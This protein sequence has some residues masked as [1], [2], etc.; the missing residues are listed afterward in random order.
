MLKYKEFIKSEN[1]VNE[2]FRTWLATFMLLLNLGLVP[3]NVYS[4]D[5]NTKKDFVDNLSSTDIV[6]ANFLKYVNDNDLELSMETFNDFKN[7]I[8]DNTINYKDVK[9]SMDKL[10]TSVGSIDYDDIMNIKPI[11]FV[12]DYADLIDD[13]IEYDFNKL[14]SDYEDSTDVEIAVLTIKNTQGYDIS[15]YSQRIGQK[16]GVGKKG[17]D[18]GLIIT[19]SV[20]DRKWNISTGYGLEYVLPDAMCKRLGEKNIP[21]NFKNGEYEKGIR[22]LIDDIMEEI[23]SENI[24]FKK[25]RMSK[26]REE[27]KAN[28]MKFLTYSMEIL[29]MIFLSY[30]VYY[31]VNRR[32]R[33]LLE[34]TEEINDYIEKAEKMGIILEKINKSNLTS[35][36]N[37]IN[38]LK[39]K[40]KDIETTNISKS[41]L[42]EISK[43]MPEIIKEYNEYIK[44]YNRIEKVSIN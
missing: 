40:L 34:L 5:M 11:N 13:N 39:N 9:R 20:E 23:G 41:R 24:E 33:K 4:S 29:L 38:T 12:S 16:W 31:L 37:S 18:N 32:K 2:G 22:E 19:I 26:E 14:L 35:F 1:N 3:K 15:D 7:S 21:P 17:Y 42:N 44:L 8:S 10:K 28:T 25:E 30:G 43:L 6:A 36:G 27:F